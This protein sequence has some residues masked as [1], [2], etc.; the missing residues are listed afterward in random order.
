M[1]TNVSKSV[2]MKESNVSAIRMSDIKVPEGIKKVTKK[3]KD[4]STSLKGVLMSYRESITLIPAEKGNDKIREY[5]KS[6]REYRASLGADATELLQNT[7]VAVKYLAMVLPKADGVFVDEMIVYSESIDR[8]GNIKIT[9]TRSD[10]VSMGVAILADNGRQEM[11]NPIDETI[12][13]NNGLNKIK[14]YKKVDKYTHAYVGKFIDYA[15]NQW[16]ADGRPSK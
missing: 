9:D 3:A 1:K 2:E 13:G 11:V 16:I 5:N 7:R 15:V 8:E 6:V 12:V 10:A 4:L 14:G